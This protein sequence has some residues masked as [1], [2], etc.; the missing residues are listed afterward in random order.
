M[1]TAVP[2]MTLIDDARAAVAAV[3]AG[4]PLAQLET[5]LQIRDR[6]IAEQRMFA[7]LSA[8]LAGVAVLLCCIGL[9]GLIAYNV[10]RRVGDIGV[11]VALGANRRQIAVPILREAVGLVVVGSLVGLALSLG[12]VQFIRS[13]LYGVGPHDPLTLVA[14]TFLLLAVALMA[15][16]PPVRRA[17]SID[18][19]DALRVE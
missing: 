19:V 16:W 8:V 9:Y 13:Q 17:T 12:G 5:Q 14:S 6:R 1:R 4:V 10:T 15:V 18:P 2:P 11:R 7:Y 3:D